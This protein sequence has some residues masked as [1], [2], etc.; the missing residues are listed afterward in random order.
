MDDINTEHLV[1]LV[2]A[3]PVLW[4]KSLDVYKNKTLKESAWREICS[5]LNENF[6]VLEQEER[7]DFGKLL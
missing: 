5:I 4:N 7:Q 6:P 3:R 2:E 1:S